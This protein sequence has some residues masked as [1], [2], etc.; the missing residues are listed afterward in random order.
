MFN[1]E[2]YRQQI[3]Y[4]YKKYDL[5]NNVILLRLVRIIALELSDIID[6]LD[7]REKKHKEE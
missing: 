5:G 1:G 4:N 3:D 2:E 7:K 6:R